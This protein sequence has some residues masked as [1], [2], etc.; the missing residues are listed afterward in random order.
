ME[1]IAVVA[2]AAVTTIAGL[3]GAWRLRETSEQAEST[4]RGRLQNEAVDLAYQRLLEKIRDTVVRVTPPGTDPAGRLERIDAMLA[5]LATELEPDSSTATSDPQE[6]LSLDYHAQGLAQARI[7]FYMSIAFG[8][9][10]AAAILVGVVLAIF[11][12]TDE[13]TVRA[14]ALSV[15]GG[16]VTDTTAVLFFRQA[17]S[18]RRTMSEL[19]DRLRVDRRGD[20]E[21]AKA[22]E[23][24]EDIQGAELRDQLRAE[25]AR[26][27]VG[28][29]AQSAVRP[30]EGIPSTT[31]LQPDPI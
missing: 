13:Q 3:I 11:A 17:N 23:L 16:V 14:A 31:Q 25:L 15:L 5:H 24:V 26:H 7:S 29:P 6:G 2:S 8:C 18:A 9:L 20:R 28:L 4:Y 19:F 10:G 27:F 30:A 21:Y 12:P 1:F 22:L